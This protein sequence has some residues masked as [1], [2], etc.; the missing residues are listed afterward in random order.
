M[1]IVRFPRSAEP[2]RT[3]AALKD[4]PRAQPQIDITV[5]K[6]DRERRY[7]IWTEAPGRWVGEVSMGRAQHSLKRVTG[8]YDANRLR[9]Q[10]KRELKDL[11]KDGWKDS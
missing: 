7:V 6:D 8:V 5:R 9:D 4:L 10:F 11:L 2:A 3:V 1:T